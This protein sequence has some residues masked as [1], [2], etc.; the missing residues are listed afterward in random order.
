MLRQAGGLAL[1][2]SDDLAGDLCATFSLPP[3]TSRGY[4]AA[5]EHRCARTL[6]TIRSYV[7]S[8]AYLADRCGV[9]EPVG[10]EKYADEAPFVVCRVVYNYWS[11]RLDAEPAQPEPCETLRSSV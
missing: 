2:T 9:T 7:A 3:T 6:S 1:I 11:Q 8:R 5:M 10:L 4:R